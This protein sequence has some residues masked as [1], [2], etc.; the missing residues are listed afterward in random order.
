MSEGRVILNPESILKQKLVEA[1][2][3]TITR[4]ISSA[5]FSR[6]VSVTILILLFCVSATASDGHSKAGTGDAAQSSSPDATRGFT[7]S[8]SKSETSAAATSPVDA[9]GMRF[10]DTTMPRG[11]NSVAAKDAPLTVK[12][13]FNYFLRRS[14]L[15]PTPYATAIAAGA[16][17]EWLDNDHH[18]HSKP[19]DFA[20]DAM[21]RAAR[22]F[23]FGTS[24]NFFEKFAYASLF[25]QDPR[26]HKSEKTGAGARIAYAVSRLF[27]TQSDQG[28]RQFNASFIAGGLTTAGLSNVWE[29]DER[30]TA[31]DTMKRWGLHV[32]FAAATNIL[33]EFIGKK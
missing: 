17:G 12:E 11:Q 16:F 10:G 4:R 28:S 1:D 6:L 18:H 27:V 9:N 8:D 25:K 20:A 7:G 29:R 26:Y 3:N 5:A 19:G 21:T 15:R 22:S 24:A 33:H 2:M 31:A 13:K 14:F 30:R 23:A 32:G